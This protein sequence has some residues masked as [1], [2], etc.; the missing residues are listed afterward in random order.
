MHAK[1]WARGKGNRLWLLLGDYGTGKTSFFRR[2]SYELAKEAGN[3][4]SP[5]PIAID[6]KDFPNA[7]SLENLLQEHLRVHANWHGNP[8]ILLYLLASGRVILLLDTFDEMGAAAAGRSIE[9]QF[10][11]LVKP[12]VYSK[13]QQDSPSSNG[14]GNRILLTCRTHFF[15]DQ[16]KVKRVFSGTAD[17]LISYDSELGELARKFNA[18]IDELMLFNDEQINR[19]LYNH[20]T[21]S[22]AERAKRFIQ[23]T[24]D[25]SSLTTR[26]VL[27]GM[28]VKSMPRLINSRSSLTSAGLY[29]IYTDEWLKDKSG[30]SLHTSPK[31]RKIILEYLAFTLWGTPGNRIH[32]RKLISV[33]ETMDPKHIAGMDHDRVDMELRTAA[34]LI[35]TRDGYYSFS[36]K[37]FMEFFSHGAC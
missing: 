29:Y 11:Q 33:I 27:L 17:H 5:I 22:Q 31:Q 19:F 18:S 30:K 20:L 35:R 2:F 25:L 37:S 6:L 10:R 32:H 21:H 24:Y 28:I 12:A 3:S 26:P 34:F 1:N 36:H 14:K 13:Q 9:E 7:I 23:N 16:Q 4:N 8:D 15:R